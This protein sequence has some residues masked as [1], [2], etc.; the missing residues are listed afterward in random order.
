MNIHVEYVVSIKKS[1]VI[2]VT[3]SLFHQPLLLLPNIPKKLAHFTPDKDLY[4][5]FKM[6]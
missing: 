6:V 4:E 2:V 1:L 5:R 3:K